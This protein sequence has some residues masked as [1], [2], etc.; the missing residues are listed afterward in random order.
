MAFEKRGIS[1][2][3]QKSYKKRSYK[4]V[5]HLPEKDGVVKKNL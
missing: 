4:R 1:Q 5:S 3:P 2:N